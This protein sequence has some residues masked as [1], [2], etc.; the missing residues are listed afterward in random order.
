MLNKKSP[1][2]S[3]MRRVEIRERNVIAKAIQPL[4]ASQLAQQYCDDMIDNLRHNVGEQKKRL[5]QKF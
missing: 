1:K 4:S 5:G 2:P 3:T